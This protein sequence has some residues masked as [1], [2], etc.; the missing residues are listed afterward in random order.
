MVCI[1]LRPPI[2]AT[3]VS[4]MKLSIWPDGFK[5]GAPECGL[6]WGGPAVVLPSASPATCPKC[7]TENREAKFSPS[8]LMGN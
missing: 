7:T 6:H 1:S 2:L 3:K 5:I 4:F 8:R